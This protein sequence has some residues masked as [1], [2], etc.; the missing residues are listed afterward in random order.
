MGGTQL[1]AVIDPE[2]AAL[3]GLRGGYGDGSGYGGGYGYG[4]SYGDGDL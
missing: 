2:A 4:D 1:T 3:T